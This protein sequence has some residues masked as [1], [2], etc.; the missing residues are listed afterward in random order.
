M[1]ESDKETRTEPTKMEKQQ[2]ANLQLQDQLDAIRK[3]LGVETTYEAVT[4][5]R[6]LMEEGVV[7]QS[8]DQDRV[9][10]LQVETLQRDLAKATTGIRNTMDELERNKKQQLKRAETITTLTERLQQA[11]TLLRSV[12]V[13]SEVD[14][15]LM[16]EVERWLSDSEPAAEP[17]TEVTTDHYSDSLKRNTGTAEEPPAQ[18]ITEPPQKRKRGRPPRDRSNDPPPPPKR[19]PGRPRKDRSTK[20]ALNAQETAEGE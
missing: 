20:T 5:V 19:S 17:A 2:H 1:L 13:P 9:T 18:S 6:R 8:V 3:A 10:A 14:G 7:L 16:Q 12:R 15:D 4:E 11:A